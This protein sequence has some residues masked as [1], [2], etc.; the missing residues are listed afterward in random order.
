MPS[1]DYVRHAARMARQLVLDAGPGGTATPTPEFYTT[2]AKALEQLAEA[3]E[4]TSRRR[5]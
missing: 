4:Q 5:D 3:V 1:T 2:L